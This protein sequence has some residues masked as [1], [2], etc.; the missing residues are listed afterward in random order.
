MQR[1]TPLTRQE[2]LRDELAAA[3]V[4]L[5]SLAQRCANGEDLSDAV[6]HHAEQLAQAGRVV[7][8][9]AVAAN[10]GRVS[11]TLSLFYGQ[12]LSTN[13]QQRDKRPALKEAGVLSQSAPPGPGTVKVKRAALTD[14]SSAMH[15]S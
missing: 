13:E 10:Q 2:R 14:H 8:V 12:Y 3:A 11:Q 4:E 9:A 1:T 6:R 15:Q 7:A 5:Q